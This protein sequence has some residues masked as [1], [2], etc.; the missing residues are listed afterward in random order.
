MIAIPRIIICILYKIV[1][2]DDRDD[3][4]D[5]KNVFLYWFFSRGCS[6]GVFKGGVSKLT[7]RSIDIVN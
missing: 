2:G 4:D 6:K 7:K 3:G 5:W 1:Y